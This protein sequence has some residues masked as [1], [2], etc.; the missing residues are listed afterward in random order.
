MSTKMPRFLIAAPKSGSGKTLL[1]CGLLKLFK[2]EGLCPCAFKCGPDYIDPMFHRTVLEIPSHNLDTFFADRDTLLDICQ[3]AGEGR[4]I[5]VMEGV[6]GLYDGLGG[7]RPEGS[8]Y[9]LAS[10]TETPIILTIDAKGMGRTILPLLSGIKGWDRE[11]R[12]KGIILNRMSKGYYEIIAP[13][14]EKETGLKV[15]GFLPQL[16]G[17]SLESRHLGLVMP[18]EI[19]DLSR[20]LDIL[21]GALREN[22]DIPALLGIARSAQDLPESCVSSHEEVKEIAVRSSVRIAVARDEAFCFYYE[23]N[24]NVLRRYG[25]EIVEFSPLHDE[26]LP[27]NIQGLLLGGGYPELYGEALSANLSMRQSVRE[28]IGRGLPALAECGGFMYLHEEME[29][30]D[31]KS[32]PMVGAIKASC[33]NTGHL[34]RFG[35]VELSEK[36]ASFLPQGAVIKGHEFHYYDSTDN[37]GDWQAVKPTTGKGWACMISRPGQLFGFPHLYYPSNPEFVRHF[38]EACRRD[39]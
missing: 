16:K 20:Q 2:E 8:A 14:I 10:A 37:G 4:G 11:D 38:T 39:R 7:T 26:K 31:G 6:M 29:A 21:A 24:L 3:R 17:V 19:R 30:S 22:V 28:A 35:Y 36:T 1:T 34:T 9:D 5:S 32:Y 23:E 25:A 15:L 27:E 13:E 18:E 33:R 12:I